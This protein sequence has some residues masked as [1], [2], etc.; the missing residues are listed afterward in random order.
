MYEKHFRVLGSMVGPN[1]NLVCTNGMGHI[2][3]AMWTHH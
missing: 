1:V 2:K 3:G